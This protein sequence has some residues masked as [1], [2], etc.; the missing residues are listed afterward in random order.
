MSKKNTENKDVVSTEK[1]QTVI[2]EQPTESKIESKDK[3]LTIAS[4]AMVFGVTVFVAGSL[5]FDSSNKSV[6]SVNNTPDATLSAGLSATP[7]IENTNSLTN[8]EKNAVASLEPQTAPAYAVSP[9]G[10]SNDQAYQAMLKQQREN[11]S[12]NF[13]Q[14]KKFITAAEKQHQEMMKR[15]SQPQFF[16]PAT[17]QNPYFIQ[18]P[19]MKTMENHRIEIMKL[20]EQRHQQFIKES[21]EAR[22]GFIK[23]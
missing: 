7:T 23:S 22:G 12:R 3:Y 1:A 15:A 20:I 13:E 9:Y 16:Q 18:D 8:Q 5:Y 21:N 11:I 2:K 19:M 6:S 14:Q 10:R 4:I 17:I